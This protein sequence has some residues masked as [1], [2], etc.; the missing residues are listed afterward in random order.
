MVRY[1][2]LYQDLCTDLITHEEQGFPCSDATVSTV[3]A[4]SLRNSLLKK[5]APGGKSP[6]ADAAAEKKFLATNSAVG[7]RTPELPMDE[8]LL[9]EFKDSLWELLGPDE[10]E[11]NCDFAFMAD[12]IAPG[13]GAS[14]KQGSGNFYEKFLTGNLSASSPYVLSLY[15][16]AIFRSPTWSRAEMQR[17]LRF[18]E[19]IADYS[20]AFFAKKNQEESRTCGTEPGVNMLF[21]KAF[22]CF[23]EERLNRWG[24]D[25]SCQADLNKHLARLGSISGLIS[26]TDLT[27]ASDCISRDLGAAYFPPTVQ[28]WVNHL[29]T[30][31][32]VLPNG[33]VVTLNMISTM[34]NGFTFA[35]QTAIFA[36]AVRA[37]TRLDGREFQTRGF[38]DWGVFGDD[39]LV[40]K[41]LTFKLH[42][43]LWLLGFTVNTSKSFTSGP[44]RESCGGDYF[45]GH[46]VRGVYIKSLDSDTDVYS[47]IN[48]LNRWSTRHAIALPRVIQ[49][50]KTLLKRRIFYVPRYESDE[51]GV[52]VP[53]WFLQKSTRSYKAYYPKVLQRVIPYADEQC[54]ENAESEYVHNGPA[55]LTTL[56]G[57]YIRSD[58]PSFGHHTDTSD[59]TVVPGL[60]VSRRDMP[61]Q[62]R[63]GTRP[64]A[65]YWWDWRGLGQDAELLDESWEAL[66]SLNC[67]WAVQVA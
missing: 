45:R 2:L 39:I 18:G 66:V 25:L 27:S 19:E 30:S 48:R 3:A 34:G 35:L 49:R 31:A 21:Q 67:P 44:F 8:A 50:L 12:H 28:K 13:P 22:S 26:T 38:K 64:R 60:V 5:L 65:T 53:S 10:T 52:K 42:R 6:K 9:D 23:I 20:K 58:Y 33:Q 29:R 14:L 54:E 46:N 32:T 47:A 36:S 1:D 61:G 37:C 11:C 17:H 16:A 7:L 56:L 43:L 24:L 59:S 63:Y 57:T 55:L 51:A 62:T 40:R 41:H 15:R 4:G